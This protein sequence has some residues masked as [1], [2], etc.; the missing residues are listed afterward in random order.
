MIIS[1]GSWENIKEYFR[2]DEELFLHIDINSSTG[3][4]HAIT[5]KHKNLL[6][7]FIFYI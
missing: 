4:T 5:L 3:N 6:T 2:T 1:N 7:Y